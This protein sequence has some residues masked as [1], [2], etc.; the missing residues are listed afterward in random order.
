MQKAG[1][2]AGCAKDAGGPRPTRAHAGPPVSR[3][4]MGWGA[5]H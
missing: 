4:Y 3:A 1:C 2:L 5:I